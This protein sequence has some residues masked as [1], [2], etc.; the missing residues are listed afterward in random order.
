MLAICDWLF[1]NTAFLDISAFT[2]N[3]GLDF[4]LFTQATKALS[5]LSLILSINVTGQHGDNRATL[6]L[7]SCHSPGFN[8]FNYPTTY[9]RCIL[10]PYSTDK[11][12]GRQV[13]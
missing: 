2:I 7:G 11:G 10:F 5:H 4:D 3:S 12:T 9:K 1:L 8:L 13:C 6:S